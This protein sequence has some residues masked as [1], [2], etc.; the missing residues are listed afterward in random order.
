MSRKACGPQRRMRRKT[1]RQRPKGQGNDRGSET[2]E[3]AGYEAGRLSRPVP[4]GQV[5]LQ[6]WC[7]TAKIGPEICD[8]RGFFCNK[9]AFEAV[10]PLV[11]I[12]RRWQGPSS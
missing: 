7:N 1:H 9:P 6:R 10:L 4:V 11:E 3:P 5:G 8:V 2:A 12:V